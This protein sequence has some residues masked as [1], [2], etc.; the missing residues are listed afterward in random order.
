M[1]NLTSPLPEVVFLE[2]TS[3]CNM[4]CRFCPSPVLRRQRGT[5]DPAT[6]QRVISQVSELNRTC[7][8]TT[9]M[10]FHCLGEP[11]LYPHL[12]EVL[13]CCE[14]LS[15]DC[16]VVSNAAL[17]DEPRLDLLFSHPLRY[18]ELSLHT[19][20]ERSFALR[21]ARISFADYLDKIEQA[22]FHPL[23][24]RHGIP[25]KLDVM[26]DLNLEQ[27]GL[28]RAFD[29]GEF[30][31]FLD[32]ADKWRETLLQLDPAVRQRCPSF[33]RARRPVR[34]RDHLVIRSRAQLMPQLESLN[35]DSGITWIDY[36]IFPGLFITVKKFF[37]FSPQERYLRQIFPRGDVNV[38]EKTGFSCPLSRELVILS[39][40]TITCCCLDYEGELGIG[41]ISKLT[42]KEALQHPQ[43]RL[44][45]QHPDRFALCRRCYGTKTFIPFASAQ[46]TE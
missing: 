11:L 29:G 32:K 21:Q 1:S 12:G 7:D 44:L 42:L 6:A 25:L 9:A 16:Y 31:S 18:L 26:Y 4:N 30:E 14:R 45:L 37:I 15:V 8:G 10:T 28:F 46:D 27:G 3:R 23:R 40:G 36:E 2:L 24:L 20:S 39:D 43:R 17:L 41:N 22:V 34:I 5:L 35:H 38:S 19:V 13:E 33:F